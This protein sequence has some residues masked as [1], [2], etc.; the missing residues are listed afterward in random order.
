MADNTMNNNACEIDQSIRPD[1]KYEAYDFEDNQSEMNKQY[2]E[3][4]EICDPEDNQPEIKKKSTVLVLVVNQMDHAAQNSFQ[5]QPRD[6]GLCSCQDGNEE[7]Y[8][9]NS[10]SM[11]CQCEPMCKRNL[12]DG[13]VLNQMGHVTNGLGPVTNEME[14][15][16]PENNKSEISKQESS[17]HERYILRSIL[18]AAFCD[19]AKASLLL[20][21]RSGVLQRLQQLQ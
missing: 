20:H 8:G 4:D 6:Q 1:Q 3:A 13:Q 12:A 18:D 11:D 14:K 5:N 21:P 16:C 17:R 19:R 2:L 9:E 7:W 10:N 15:K